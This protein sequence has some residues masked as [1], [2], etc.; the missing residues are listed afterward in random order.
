MKIFFLFILLIISDAVPASESST[1]FPDV[2]NFRYKL[3]VRVWNH[4]NQVVNCSGL[5]RTFSQLGFSDSQYFFESVL[6]GMFSVRS[7][8]PLRA[9]DQFN[10]ADHSIFCR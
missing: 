3:E 9:G 5:I 6:P 4:S 7:I 1:I 8:Y 10:Y 2:F